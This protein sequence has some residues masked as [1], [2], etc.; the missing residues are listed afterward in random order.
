[1]IRGL[2]DAAIASIARRFYCEIG[3]L[4]KARS[5]RWWRRD[6]RFVVLVSAFAVIL[7]E[8][9]QVLFILA[10]RISRIRWFWKNL[11][12]C[13]RARGVVD[14][15][16]SSVRTLRRRRFAIPNRFVRRHALTD[17]PRQFGK[18]IVS[19]RPR[20]F[21]LAAPPVRIAIRTLIVFSHEISTRS[22]VH[23]RNQAKG[24]STFD[25]HSPSATAERQPR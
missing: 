12:G 21:L 14:L 20:R 16:A 1:V 24:H 19:L 22:A 6:R 9:P 5:A 23:R 4:A 11:F 15:V 17:E 8:V 13:G 7:I 25:P 10:G 2:V 3:L 18:R